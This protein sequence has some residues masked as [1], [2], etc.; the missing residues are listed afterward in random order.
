[1]NKKNAIVFGK[2]TVFKKKKISILSDYNIFCFLDNAVRNQQY[3]DELGVDVFNPNNIS[4]L[5]KYDIVC[6]SDAWFQMWRQL[7]ELGVDDE[8]VKFCLNM[9]PCQ[10]GMET[11]AFGNGET[12]ISS[13][14][15]LIY[16]SELIGKYEIENEEDI[17]KLVRLLIEKKSSTLKV[18]GDMEETPVSRVFGSERGKAVDRY[19]IERYLSDNAKYI[20]GSVLEVLNNKYTLMFGRDK[21]SESVVSHVKGWGDNTVLCNFETGEGVIQN[22]YDCII[23]TQTLQYIYDLSSAIKNIYKMLRKG[24]SALITVPGIKPLCVYDSTNWGEYWSFTADSL[25]RLCS[26]VC[27]EKDFELIQYGNVKVTTAYLYGICVEELKESDFELNDP[28]FPFLI[29]ARISKE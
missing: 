25:K 1:M 9:F 20:K 24:G 18:F 15:K 4:E 26:E 13:G 14:Q 10:E 29:C 5:P 2:G 28:Q 8:R 27:S 3:D 21:V 7:K 19:Y 23:C 22:R 17:K 12:I 11:I 6:A 16:Q